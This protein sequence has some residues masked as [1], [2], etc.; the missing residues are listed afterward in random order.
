MI[1]SAQ[2]EKTFLDVLYL[3]RIL[4]VEVYAKVRQFGHDASDFILEKEP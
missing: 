1:P 4:P 2:R 3:F